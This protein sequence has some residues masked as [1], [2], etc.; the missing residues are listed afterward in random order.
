MDLYPEEMRPAIDEVNSWVYTDINNG[1]YKCAP[2]HTCHTESYVRRVVMTV[3]LFLCTIGLEGG[4]P[5]AP[6]HIGGGGRGP[7]LKWAR[8][9]VLCFSVAH[10]YTIVALDSEQ[11]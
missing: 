6:P 11:N 2:L 5:R 7:V 9:G 3:P 8:P 1:V 4:H 10:E